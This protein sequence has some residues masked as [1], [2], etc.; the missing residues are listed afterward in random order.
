M[1]IYCPKCEWKPTPDCRW[2]CTC[3]CTW[4]TFDTR[5]VCPDCGKQWAE[6]QCHSC[7]GMS[8]HDDWYVDL[9]G[10]KPHLKK[11][12]TESEASSQPSATTSTKGLRYVQN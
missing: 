3:G 2:D 1:K 12:E 8:P 9:D 6:T 4:N 10:T 7:H 5:A 11:E